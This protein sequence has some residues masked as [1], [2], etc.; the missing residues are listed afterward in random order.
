MANHVNTLWL[1]LIINVLYITD[2]S[3]PF[4][5]KPTNA[6]YLNISDFHEMRYVS[7]I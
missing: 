4:H 6:L 1:F 2:K 5:M 3:G 7:K